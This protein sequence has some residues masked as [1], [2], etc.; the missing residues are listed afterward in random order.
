MRKIFSPVLEYEKLNGKKKIFIIY[1]LEF[2]G[3]TQRRK[4]WLAIIN[5]VCVGEWG[6]LFIAMLLCV[7]SR[8]LSLIAAKLNLAW[9][10]ETNSFAQYQRWKIKFFWRSNEASAM[11]MKKGQRNIVMEIFLSSVKALKYLNN[12]QITKF[13]NIESSEEGNVF[14]I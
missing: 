7:I 4:G 11:N 5:W 1:T 8:V 3:E 10:F 13:N 9:P 2:S 12:L 14:F 6:A